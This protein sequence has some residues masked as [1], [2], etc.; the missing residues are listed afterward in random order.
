MTNKLLFSIMEYNSLKKVFY[1]SLL[2]GGLGVSMPIM[3]VNNE[4]QLLTSSNVEFITKDTLQQY[5]INEYTEPRVGTSPDVSEWS[6]LTDGLHA[7][8]ASR[9]VHYE[10]HRIPELVQTMDTTISAWRGE[11]A[12]I[13]AVLYSKSDQ[14]KLKVRMTPWKRG[15]K[16]TKV[17][18]GDARF[19]NYVITDDYKS[20]GNHPTN[21]QPWLVPDVIDQ[22]KAHEV[23]AMETRPIWCTFEVPRDIKP[24]AYFTQL[25]IVNAKGKVVRK[26]SLT[27]NVN[28]RTLPEVAKQKFHLDFWQQ[29]YA[30]SRYYAVERWSKEHLE[31]LRPYLQALGRAGQRTVSTIMF[32][33]PWGEQTH[34]LFDPMVKTTKKA[35]GTWTYDYTVFDQYV[36]LC[37]EYGIDKYI[38]CFSMVPWDMKFRYWDEATGSYQFLQTSTRTPEYRELWTN[39]LTAFKVHLVK[40]GW[41][42]KTNIAMD[43]RA[44]SDM[45]NAYQIASALGFKMALAGNYHSSLSDKLEDF[46]V[47]LGQDKRFTPEQRAARRAKGQVTTIYTSCADVEPNIYSNSLPAEAA[48]LPLYAAANDLDGYLHWAWIN[49]DEHPL[50]DSRFRKFGAGDTYC[51]YPGNRSSVRFER[52]IEGIHQFEKV[53]IL[54][55]EYK[56]NPE[57]MAKLNAL[58]ETFKSHAVVGEDCAEKVNA[59]EKFLN[60]E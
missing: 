27:I 23:P 54:K 43:E 31:A 20:C 45:L 58:L 36:E 10:L 38:N 16:R 47:A 60:A 49:W 2:L 19:V 22:D 56:D 14:G 44:E 9:D 21:L 12:N 8:W 42:E 55:E 17:D 50:T 15:K 3:A 1:F 37:A 51:Y 41:F 13:Q 4:S 30:V 29:P 46:C 39:F 34:D 11:R 33:E 24:G 57:K 18:G 59:I 53:Q 35:D 40:K 7:S 32:Y 25:E 28:Q 5:P 52:L 26:L 6:K 48:F